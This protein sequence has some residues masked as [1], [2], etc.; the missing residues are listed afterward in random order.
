[1]QVDIQNCDMELWA[2][3]HPYITPQ[4]QYLSRVTSNNTNDKYVNATR[5][6]CINFEIFY[7]KLFTLK[8]QPGNNLQEL[9][10]SVK[11]IIYI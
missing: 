9:Q 3:P 11:L 8:D 1:M 6:V 5:P 10:A 2:R 7:S 4:G